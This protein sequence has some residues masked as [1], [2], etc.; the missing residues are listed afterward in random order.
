MAVT[1][2]AAIPDL[3]SRL[4]NVHVDLRDDL[5]ISRHLFHGEPSYI[6]RDPISFQS[7]QFSLGD[8]RILSRI[9][10]DASLDT[11]F[12][13]LVKAGDLTAERENE[14][15][16]FILSLHRAGL[17]NLPIADGKLLY[18][19]HKAGRAIKRRRLLLSF[20]Y[21]DLPLWN[22]DEFLTRTVRFARP[23]FTRRS[24]AAWAL[25]MVVALYVGVTRWAE[26]GDP[27]AGILA[28]RNLVIMWFTLAGL[29]VIHEL[30]HAFACKH[31]G[32][33][34]PTLGVYLVAGI[35]CA[36][37]DASAA[38]GLASRRQRLIIGLGG[39]YFETMVS[40]AAMLVW[41]MT[42]PG[43]VNSIAFNVVFLAS[44]VTVVFNINPLMKYDGYFMLSDILDIPNLGQH[45]RARVAELAK[46]WLLNL[47]ASPEPARGWRRSV[48][49]VYGVAAP[50]YRA[51]VLLA[52]AVVLASRF[53]VIGLFLGGT[54]LLYVVTKLIWKTITYLWRAEETASVR[55]RAVALS[56]VLL[57]LLPTALA[58]VPMRL[59]VQVPG[60]IL[61][62][63]EQTVRAETPG[64]VTSVLATTGSVVQAGE[65]L[66]ELS[67]DLITERLVEAQTRQDA[68]EVR[69]DAFRDGRPARAAEEERRAQALREQVRHHQDQVEALRRCSPAPGKVIMK[70]DPRDTGRFIPKGDEI[71]TVVSG[72]PEVS[73]LLTAQEFT[74]TAP[75]VG[76]PIQCRSVAAPTKVLT[77]AIARIYPGGQRSVPI[78]A[79]SCL[80]GGD[81]PVRPETG[82]SLQPYFLIIVRLDNGSHGD[83][84]HGVRAVVRLP[85]RWEPFAIH[86][87]R[88]VSRFMDALR[89]D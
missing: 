88:R 72:P 80:A 71:A 83:L 25:L 66:V 11:V 75:W 16:G 77:G 14:F 12:A 27:L 13:S 19:R 38:W 68:A 65:P 21:L 81:I 67:N 52:I 54:Y 35:P 78:P 60:V 59:A 70:L 22:P 41:A 76:E 49:V 86:F 44:V 51:S 64:F 39:M 29:K 87:Y 43:L 46:R 23:L 6:V 31:Y 9:N 55:V 50:L 73:M 74:A 33:H 56:V 28:V 2:P 17:L 20:V 7:H 84:P 63:R 18:R 69:R 15:Y 42:P 85:S 47:P 32:L 58:L 82:E 24:F 34:V 89:R 37:V 79:L 8:Y 5:K 48:L 62:G 26:L 40:A 1:A 53:F 10:S 45:A 61:G 57:I 36:Y 4:R 30:G 3:A